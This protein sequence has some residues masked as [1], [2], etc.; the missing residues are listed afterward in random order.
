M[1]EELAIHHVLKRSCSTAFPPTG[2]SAVLFSAPRHRPSLT[3]LHLKDCAFL[4]KPEYRHLAP[5]LGAALATTPFVGNLSRLGGG[6]QF[7]DP[8][9]DGLSRAS[10]MTSLLWFQLMREGPLHISRRKSLPAAY[11]TPSIMGTILGVSLSEQAA[12]VRQALRKHH[13]VKSNY[14][15]EVQWTG[16]SLNRWDDLFVDELS[17]LPLVSSMW[18]VALWEAA[19]S[20]KCFLDFLKAADLQLSTKEGQSIFQEDQDWVRAVLNDPYA[21]KEWLSGTLLDSSKLMC[22]DYLGAAL[23]RVLHYQSWPKGDGLLSSEDDHAFCNA[24]EIVCAG[25]ALQHFPLACKPAV[26]NGYFAIDGAEVKAGELQY[27]LVSG[28]L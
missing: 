27:S 7:E 19:E 1:L 23:E 20:K 6:L 16:V 4:L 10:E 21:E 5:C 22:S 11:L 24:L 13:G 2:K 17:P 8:L 28:S 18:L 15:N 3:P 14:V 9:A 25:I 12:D 26:G